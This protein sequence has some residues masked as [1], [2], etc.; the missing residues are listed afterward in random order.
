MVQNPSIQEKAQDELISAKDPG[1]A[2]QA[3]SPEKLADHGSTRPIT[4]L[5]QL[6]DRTDSIEGLDHQLETPSSPTER[7][8]LLGTSEPDTPSTV[9][10]QRPPAPPCDGCRPGSRRTH[11]C[12]KRRLQRD[13]GSSMRSLRARLRLLEEGDATKNFT[14][15]GTFEAPTGLGL[16]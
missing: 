9:L 6:Q 2:A 16:P 11:T 15:T 13:N 4:Q 7:T 10:V 12:S 14:P 8:R 5:Q 3:A 1:L